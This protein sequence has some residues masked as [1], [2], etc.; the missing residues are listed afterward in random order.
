MEY[1]TDVVL[2]K[3]VLF[4]N[5]FSITNSTNQWTVIYSTDHEMSL[6]L[7]ADL[8]LIVLQTPT[9]GE[10]KHFVMFPICLRFGGDVCPSINRFDRFS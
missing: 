4:H 7:N 6:V 2:C 8:A 3:T 5:P 1:Y 10:S 9:C